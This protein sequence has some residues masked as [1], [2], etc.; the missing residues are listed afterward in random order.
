MLFT[1]VRYFNT[2]KYL[3]PSQ[4]FFRLI[5]I[6]FKKSPKISFTPKLR[7]VSST[8]I[9]PIKK[10]KS[11][12]G[13]YTF[14]F[15]NKIGNIRSLGWDN[16]KQTKLWRYN[17]HYFDY[18]NA[19]A[20]QKCTDWH[21]RLMTEWVI[22]N[23][24]GDGSGWEPY[25][26]SL[27]I[28]NWVKWKLSKESMP[29]EILNSLA[30]QT[31]WLYRRIEWHI[32]GNHLFSNAK[33]LVF[34]GLFFKGKE[35]DLWLSKGLSI[36][37]NELSEQILNDGGH[38]ERS[39][40]YHALFLEDLLD[41]INLSYAYSNHISSKEVELWK[42]TAQKMM[43]FLE[44]MCH[45]DGEISFFN[46]AAIGIAPSKQSLR[47][48]GKRVGVLESYIN[49]SVKTLNFFHFTDSGYIRLESSSAYAI[50][51]VA[52]IGP[53]YLT[54]HAHADTLAF[55]LSIFSL[56]VIVNGGTSLYE[57]GP[58]RLKERGTSSH[59]TVEI[60]GQNSSDVWSS[61]RV[62]KRAYPENLSI[63][64]NENEIHICCYHNGYQRLEGKPLHQR[65]W[66]FKENSLQIEDKIF[67][68]FDNAVARFYLHPDI[69]VIKVKKN[70]YLL[71]TGI[72]SLILSISIGEA[73]LQ[74]GFYAPEFGKRLKT[75]C[76]AVSFKNTDNIIVE[77]NWNKNDS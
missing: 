3:K 6:Y 2:L 30:T 7:N 72:R 35:P 58:I 27:R 68:K 69:K 26:T 13:P 55:E 47:H 20:N 18:L 41:L 43:K 76:L 32:L 25:P 21:V 67:N 60:N 19:E 24:P 40:M 45:P 49:E 9:E 63:N 65:I 64:K 75:K 37:K 23:K 34:S 59:S 57:N 33:A 77:I 53:D 29:S 42:Q 10:I 44:E 14:I 66:K 52:P 38:F 5:F 71:K 15:L 22:E 28:V 36:I 8:F 62:G 16:P 39:P 17:L 48:Y 51:D 4:I 12:V 70:L 54:G 31:R 11:L 56:R 50:L 74:N 1:I 46:D 73:K 61:F